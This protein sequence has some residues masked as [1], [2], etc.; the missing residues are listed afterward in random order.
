VILPVYNHRAFVVEAIQSVFAQ[1]L[2]PRELII[3]DDGSTDGSVEI[4]QQFLASTPPPPG[5]TVTSTRAKTAVPTSRST[6]LARARG[7]YFAIL[8]SDDAYCRNGSSAA[9][10]QRGRSAADWSLRMSKASI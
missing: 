7:E 9:L 5:T 1:T 10:R 4:V 6:R 3:I 2:P 8:N